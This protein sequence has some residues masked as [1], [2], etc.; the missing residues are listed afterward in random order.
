MKASFILS[1]RS[2]QNI[3]G[4]FSESRRRSVSRNPSNGHA[5]VVYS[6]EKTVHDQQLKGIDV[7][8]FPHHR[9]DNEK[10]NIQSDPQ[11]KPLTPQGI[12]KGSIFR[13][14]VSN[15]KIIIKKNLKDETFAKIEIDKKH[16]ASLH[17]H[18]PSL[19]FKGYISIQL[20]AGSS[21]ALI[22][23]DGQATQENLQRIQQAFKRELKRCQ[24]VIEY[25]DS[26]DTAFHQF[27]KTLSHDTGVYLF[28]E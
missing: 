10:V 3:D 2:K 16:I 24:F 8:D 20:K 11:E 23:H 4:A 6:K 22:N 26:K 7:E 25:A 1:N 28:E 27:I 9:N 12:L 15:N 19:L 5:N 13:I 18:K 17:H 21:H 14:K